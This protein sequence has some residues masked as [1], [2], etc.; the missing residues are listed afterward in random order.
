MYA[1]FW[2]LLAAF[3]IYFA[4]FMIPN[5]SN[6]RANFERVRI[7]E[8]ANE[9]ASTCERL[10]FKR[11]TAEFGRCLLEIGDFRAKVENRIVGEVDW[12]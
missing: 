12:F 11:S 5:M 9:N 7:Q 3:V 10:G 1:A 2:A 4:V 6:I 8:I